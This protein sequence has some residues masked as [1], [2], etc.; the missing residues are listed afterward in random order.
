[1]KYLNMYLYKISAW[2]PQYE[3]WVHESYWIYQALQYYN[4]IAAVFNLCNIIC[5]KEYMRMSITKQGEN[6]GNSMI[7]Q[8][9]LDL[10]IPIC[11][12]W[13]PPAA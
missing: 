9:S 5:K 1:M 6:I 3:R 2:K 4:I 8:A 12:V 7:P 11:I 13:V 10:D